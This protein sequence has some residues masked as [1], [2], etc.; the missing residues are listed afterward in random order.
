MGGRLAHLHPPQNRARKKF[1]LKKDVVGGVD[2]PHQ[3]GVGWSAPPPRRLRGFLFSRGV[4]PPNPPTQSPQSPKVCRRIP[5]PSQSPSRSTFSSC[6]TIHPLSKTHTSNSRG[7]GT[8][9]LRDQ[10][11]DC[12]T[13]T[14]VELYTEGWVTQGYANACAFPACREATEELRSWKTMELRWGMA[15]SSHVI[16]GEKTHGCEASCNLHVSACPWSRFELQAEARKIKQG[17]FS[18]TPGARIKDDCSKKISI[19][20]TYG[21]CQTRVRERTYPKF[22]SDDHKTE[23]YFFKQKNYWN[24]PA[25]A[26]EIDTMSCKIC[27]RAF[28][29]GHTLPRE[30]QNSGPK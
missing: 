10:T 8:R 16:G 23:I 2:P 4:D 15:D 24:I 27:T 1:E 12:V 26:A 3:Y 13:K 6:P 29:N 30:W 28:V 20:L 22:I 25:T 7:R 19:I 5:R 14:M 11:G 18:L 17:I 9:R 21:F